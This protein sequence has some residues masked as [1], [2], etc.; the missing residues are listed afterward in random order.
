[1]DVQKNANAGEILKLWSS[2]IVTSFIIACCILKGL[3]IHVCTSTWLVTCKS[4]QV[5]EN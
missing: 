4:S 1:M 5:L 2:S 3:L